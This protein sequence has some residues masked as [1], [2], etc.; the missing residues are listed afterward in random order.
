MNKILVLLALIIVNITSA[1]TPVGSEFTYQGSLDVNNTPA[2]GVFDFTFKIFDSTTSGNQIGSDFIAD[3]LMVIDGFFTAVIDF[4]TTAFVGN[5]V[6]MEIY[7]RNGAESGAF[8]QLLPRQQITSTPYAIHAQFVSAG[9]VSSIEIQNGSIAN[10]DLANNSVNADKIASGSVSS[11]EIGSNAVGTAEIISTQ[12]QRR[13]GN[14]CASGSYINTVNEDGTVVCEV[15]DSG[16]SNVTSADIVDG[17]VATIDL[18]NNS[19]TAD[20]IATSSVGSDEIS[21]NAVGTTEII[22]SQ[23]QRRVS[24][25]CSEAYYLNG[26]NEDGSIICKRLPAGFAFTIDSASYVGEYTSLAIGADNNP[27][28]SYHD[29]S[30]GDLKVVKCSNAI[31]GSF[32]PP[33]TLDAMGIV[34]EY[35]SLAIGADNNP[36]ISYHDVTNGDLKVVK[37]STASCS[38]FNPPVTLDTTGI[39]GWYTSLAIGADDN[40]IIS[41][42]DLTNANLK[43]VQC[44]NASCSSFNSPVTLDATGDVGRYTSLAI[45]ADNNPIISYYD[46]SIGDL[47]VVQCSTASCSSSNTPLTL[48]QTGVVGQDTSLAI[49]ADDNPI[50]SYFDTSNSALKVV[51]CTNASCGSF[52]PPVTLDET[53]N[54]G[55]YTSLAIGAD[56]NPVISYQDG[57]NFNLKVVKCSNAS[58][59]RFNPPVILDS[60]GNVGKHTSVA[61]GADDNPVISHFDTT[62]GDLKVY[63]CGDTECRR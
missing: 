50:I 26:I 42:F 32:N 14:T 53:G 4:N 62:N 21:S 22:S 39:V 36:V 2:N 38:S 49:G 60:V 34:G 8:Q 56:N 58:C 54:V 5:K 43:V 17:T 57:A 11:D 15:D 13:I 27:V 59:S 16:I 55:K 9:A 23:V 25:T 29:V 44:S 28:I 31:C 24:A 46:S 3:D 10:V 47:K 45:G 35:T 37:C 19:V 51:K 30:N 1:Q 12:V 20:K 63:S 52:N 7:V 41:Y 48:D 61:I 33:V 18:A 40:P 6:W